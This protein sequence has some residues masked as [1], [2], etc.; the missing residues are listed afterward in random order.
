MNIKRQLLIVIVAAILAIGGAAAYQS[1]ETKREQQQEEEER[2][3]EEAAKKKEEEKRNRQIKALEAEAQVIVDELAKVNTDESVCQD[4][5]LAASTARKVK[6]KIQAFQE[7]HT[8]EEESILKSSL[9]MLDKAMESA[10][11]LIRMQKIDKTLAQIYDSEE[12]IVAMS[13]AKNDQIFRD[14]QKEMW[15]LPQEAYPKKMEAYNTAISEISEA[16]D[17]VNDE[18]HYET[19]T[20]KVSVIPKKNSYT[21]YWICHIQTFSTQQMCSALS[22]GTYGNPRTKTSAEVADHNGVIGINGSGFDYGSG[23]PAPGKSMI[24]SGKVYNDTYSNGNIMCVTR[25]GGMFTAIAGMTTEDMLNRGVWDTYCF[26]PTLVENGKAY[27]ITS[28]FQ[29]TYRY[30]RTVI[31]MVN[32]GDYY[33]LVVDGKGAGGSE[34]MT[35]EEMQKVLLDL[36]CQYAYNLD[37]GGSTTL[38]FKG[39]VINSLTD[40]GNERPCADILYFIDAGDGGEGDDIIIHE[41][42]AMLKPPSSGE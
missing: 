40:G 16:W 20:L 22:G 18:Y 34:G 19:S 21:K 25:D 35:Y 1:Y 8:E 14:V 33:I 38:V 4:V 41:D 7:A 31:G 42:E 12:N 2:A 28:A 26:G 13:T 9:E 6:K 39:R 29:Q 37:G 3:A 10:K 24:K 32:P 30:Q 27:E 23:I 11:A 17:Y 15:K 5:S 36:N